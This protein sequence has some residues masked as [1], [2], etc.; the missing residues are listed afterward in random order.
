MH[1][2]TIRRVV[3]GVDGAPRTIAALRWA[4]SE[5]LSRDAALVAVHAWGSVL[6]PASY[7]PVGTACS[8]PDESARRAAELLSAAVRTAFGA[9]PPV[10]VEEVV[11]D[12]AVVPSLLSQARRAELLVVATR[13]PEAPGQPFESGPGPTTLS[14]LRQ[15]PCPVVVLPTV[16]DQVWAAG[17]R[18]AGDEAP[19]T[20]V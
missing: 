18:P 7:A 9:A 5:A 12:R 10:P 13:S 11:D 17:A 3:V 14:C 2:R 8:D 15:A 19:P 16:G 1:P 4:A 6:R 20:L